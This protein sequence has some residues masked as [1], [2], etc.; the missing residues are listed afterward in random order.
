MKNALNSATKKAA[1][2]QATKF[3]TRRLFVPAVSFTQSEFENLFFVEFATLNPGVW[4]GMAPD[5]ALGKNNL[6]AA[7]YL[8]VLIERGTV[9]PPCH[10]GRM[11]YVGGREVPTARMASLKIPVKMSGQC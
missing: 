5:Y 1:Q 8:S 9:A 3:P 2:I 10:L 7:Q 11:H 6:L 4:E